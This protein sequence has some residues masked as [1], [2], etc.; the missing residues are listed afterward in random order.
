MRDPESVSHAPTNPALDQEGVPANV[1]FADLTPYV[2]PDAQC[3][4]V[5]GNV[6]TYRDASHLTATFSASLAPFIADA[7]L[8]ATGW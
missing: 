8:D 3:P 2:C 6:L 4:P 7:V 1:A 5:I